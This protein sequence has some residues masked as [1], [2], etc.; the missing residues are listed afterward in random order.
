[1]LTTDYAPMS[2]QGHTDDDEDTNSS[3]DGSKKNG[4]GGGRKRKS[5]YTEVDASDIEE[6]RKKNRVAAKKCREKKQKQVQDLEEN[7]KELEQENMELVRQRDELINQCKVYEQ[8]IQQHK[9]QGCSMQHL[10]LPFD[11][12]ELLHP[13]T[14]PP[15]SLS[16]SPCP[17]PAPSTSPA[18]SISP[19]PSQHNHPETPAQMLQHVGVTNVRKTEPGGEP[20][21]NTIDISIPSVATSN[22]ESGVQVFFVKVRDGDKIR[23]LQFTRDQWERAQAAKMV[24]QQQVHTHPTVQTHSV[25]RVQPAPASRLQ[26]APRAIMQ[27]A[28]SASA[29]PS[30]QQVD[31]QSYI[32]TEPGIAALPNGIQN[33]QINLTSEQVDSSKKLDSITDV[34]S[35]MRGHANQGLVFVQDNDPEVQAMVKVEPPDY[36]DPQNGSSTVDYHKVAA[37]QRQ[38][39][40]DSSS[41]AGPTFVGGQQQLTAASQIR[42]SLN[43]VHNPEQAGYMQL[44]EQDDDCI[45]MPTDNQVFLSASQGQGMRQQ[46]A[47]RFVTSVTPSTGQLQAFFTNAKGRQGQV[48]V[49]SQASLGS[50]QSATSQDTTVE[51]QHVVIHAV[52]GGTQTGSRHPPGVVKLRQHAMISAQ[53]SDPAASASHQMVNQHQPAVST[54]QMIRVNTGQTQQRLN[55][56]LWNASSMPAT[57]KLALFNPVTPRSQVP[58]A[59]KGMPQQQEITTVNMQQFQQLNGHAAV[60]SQQQLLADAM[61]QLDTGADALNEQKSSEAQNLPTF[62]TGQIQDYLANSSIESMYAVNSMS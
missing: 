3:S 61:E 32:K 7:N 40:D 56:C 5:T 16:N 47:P 14:P 46:S 21:A 15:P 20:L 4:R 11:I 44:M 2:Q 28:V 12:E 1:M 6:K 13:S 45:M 35:V 25:P 8:E 9:E 51:Q 34:L 55:N 30:A 41:L 33:Q 22:S 50:L 29:M 53:T 48:F 10:S 17:S 24:T 31:H 23:T 42:E 49:T 54:P 52:Q 26:P 18:P 27:T 19:C 57:G 39:M 58:A 59:S 38:L 37:I 36:D 43:A 60:T 62:S